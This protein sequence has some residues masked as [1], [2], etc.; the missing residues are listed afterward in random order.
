MVQILFKD[1]L[2]NKEQ[3]RACEAYWV[4]LIQKIAESLGQAG[5]WVRWIPRYRP[6]RIKLSQII[7]IKKQLIGVWSG[8]A[9]I[10][11]APGS[12]TRIDDLNGFT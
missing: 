11:A 3:Y 9:W 6:M 4:H 8:T 5:E 10:H 12:Q 7:A 2:K 1:F